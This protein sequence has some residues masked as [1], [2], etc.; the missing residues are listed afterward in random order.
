MPMYFA[1][2]FGLDPV[3]LVLVVVSL[4]MGLLTQSYINKTYRT[5]SKVRSD[6]ATGADVARRML[7][8]SGCTQVGIKSVAGRLTDHYDPRDNNLYLSDENL[9]GGSVASIA[10]ACH[11]AGHAIQRERG[12]A[13]MRVRTAL[14]PV[15]NFTQGAWMFVFIFGVMLSAVNLQ[16][17]AIVLF[18]FSVV[19]QVVTLPVEIDASRRAVAYIEGSGMSELNV[20]GARSVLTAAAL[21]YVAAALSSI[22]QLIYL[23]SRSS[24]RN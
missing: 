2:G 20:S 9:R 17:L 1:Y 6:G 11:E 4:A 18:A 5:W 15:V 13:L 12:Y 23:L 21:T 3:Y 10:V 14:V 22:M 19:F 7:D 24:R 8:S 16:M